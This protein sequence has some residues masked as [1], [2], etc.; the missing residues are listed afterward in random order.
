MDRVAEFRITPSDDERPGAYVCFPYDRELVRRFRASF[1]RAR[2]RE[3]GGWFVPGVRAAARL[4]AWIAHE[5]AAL[6]RHADDK[7]RDDFAFDPWDSDYLEVGPEDLEVRTPYSRTVVEA[8]RKI[9]WARWDPLARAWRVPFRSVAELRRA[10]PTIEAAAR[11]NEPE[12]RKARAAQRT[13]DPLERRRQAD[14]R[15]GRYPVPADDSPPSGMPVGTL[16]GVVVFEDSGGEL[17][18]D[19]AA[20]A[21]PFA[22]ADRFVWA[23]W[24][25]P[26]FR[27][28]KMSKPAAMRADVE[29]GWWQPT[30]DEIDETRARL[31]RALRRREARPAEA[32]TDI[33]A[34]R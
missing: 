9:P 2:W 8:L 4:D 34:R 14:R 28:L 22:E 15:G 31:G 12:A 18:D 26:T 32:A 3:K 7:G 24:R 10:W 20:A 19:E 6:D 25:L 27:E 11:R 23:D 13:P 33:S 5:L 30:A 29:R 21:Y 1:P 16:F 17:L